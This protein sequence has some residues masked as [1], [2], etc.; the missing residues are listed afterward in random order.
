[1]ASKE[2]TVQKHVLELFEGIYGD[3]V[4]DVLSTDPNDFDMD[5]S[6]FY[7]LLQEM[8]AVPY[9]DDNDYFG[10]YGGAV[11]DTIKFLADNWDGETLNAVP[12]PP[13]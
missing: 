6:M 8:F 13:R 12:M 7:E 10:G 11:R 5:P 2:E 4:D 9:D 1:V 3:D